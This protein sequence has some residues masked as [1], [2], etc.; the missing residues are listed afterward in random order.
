MKKDSFGKDYSNL[1]KTHESVVIPKEQISK[2]A[3]KTEEKKTSALRNLAAKFQIATGRKKT[4]T[5]DYSLPVES[6]ES[7]KSFEKAAEKSEEAHFKAPVQIIPESYN[8]NQQGKNGSCML[9]WPRHPVYRTGQ[10]T[11]F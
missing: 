4:T 6:S 3:S 11:G 1:E 10:E 9:T 7:E 8:Q 2:P 5:A